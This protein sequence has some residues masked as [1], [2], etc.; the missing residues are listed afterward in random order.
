M[1]ALISQRCERGPHGD[2]RD[3]LEHT[4]VRFFEGLGFDLHPVSNASDRIDAD[5]AGTDAVILSGG[6]DIHPDSYGSH[7]PPAPTAVLERDRV[8]F[9]LLTGAI[10]RGLPVLGICR[11][12]QFI[13]VFFGGRL[14]TDVSRAPVGAVHRPGGEHPVDF[15][16]GDAARFLG[17]ESCDV[18]S[19]HCQGVTEATLAVALRPFARHTPSAVIEGLFHPGHP[20]AGV[21][22]H[23]ER[24]TTAA[25]IDLRLV[26]AFRDRSLFWRR[27]A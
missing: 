14:E 17:A 11:G 12:M 16:D 15:V 3:A 1:R 23:P 26:E 4:Y 13:N 18:N 8:E 9:R 21:Q 2:L 22:Y 25:P 19:F 7:L 10:A 6:N 5:L 20:I 24:R 27:T